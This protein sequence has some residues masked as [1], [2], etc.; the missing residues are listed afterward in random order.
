MPDIHARDPDNLVHGR[1]LEYARRSGKTVS[2]AVRELLARG[3]D[4]SSGEVIDAVALAQQVHARIA[5]LDGRI[6]ANGDYFRAMLI[7]LLEDVMLTRQI[8]ALMKPEIVQKA[9]QNA[10]SAFDRMVL[11][12]TI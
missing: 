4:A 10:R 5:A 12:G 7:T 2:E 6:P 11:D 9:Q 3:L 1:V 8:A